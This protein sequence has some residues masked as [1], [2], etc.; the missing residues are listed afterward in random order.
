MIVYKNKKEKDRDP[1]KVTPKADL[2]Q[3]KV[4]LSIWWD[5]KGI[6]SYELLPPN[7]TINDNDKD[8]KDV[9]CEQIDK[10]KKEI[11]KKKRP[12]LVNR[13]GVIF[14]HDNPRPHTFLKTQEKL[15]ELDWDVLL[16]P[17]YS[18][19]LTLSDY[20]LFRSLEHHF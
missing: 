5:W 10:F 9:Y 14:H 6:L 7:K 18:S 2:H 17:P 12:E 1:P 11:E 19:D 3:K 13:R 16:H 4:M 8:D 15:S 20:H